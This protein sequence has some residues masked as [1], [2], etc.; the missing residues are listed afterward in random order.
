MMGGSSLFDDFF[1]RDPFDDPFFTR[2][3]GMGMGSGLLGGGLFGGR[4]PFGMMGMGMGMNSFFDHSAFF[5]RPDGSL[6]DH[7]SFRPPPSEPEGRRGPIIEELTDDAEE[8]PETKAEN[9]QN[10]IVEHPE[11]VEE[12]APRSQRRDSLQQIPSF[13]ALN[14]RNQ[15]QSNNGYQ[16]NRTYQ[17]Y[18]FQSSSTSFGGSGGSYYSS[19]S[20]RR[21]GPDG[22]VQEEHEERDS[23][24]KESRTSA[25]GLREQ[26]H[27]ITKKRNAASGPESTV[28]TLRNLTPEEAP[29]FDAQWE[30]HAQRSLPGWNRGRAQALEGNYSRSQRQVPPAL[31]YN[32]EGSQPRMPRSYNH[33]L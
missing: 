28:E 18:S 8:A 21:V 15:Q 27:A 3:M 33:A 31:R 11:D 32:D 30:T 26:V 2:P 1:S 17:S 5:S 6:L 25:R 22:V 12:A 4:S 14:N 7:Q 10:P 9:E 29:H 13:H 24:G 23:S 20:M 19:S 16:S